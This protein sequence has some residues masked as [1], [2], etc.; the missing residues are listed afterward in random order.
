MLYALSRTTACTLS[1]SIFQLVSMSLKLEAILIP[2]WEPEKPLQCG[3]QSLLM[4]S[5]VSQ[6][7]VIVINKSLLC[8]LVLMSVVKEVRHAASNSFN[9][10]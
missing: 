9:N 5:F 1:T 2:V 10:C 8:E 7:A 4:K 3:T 6:C